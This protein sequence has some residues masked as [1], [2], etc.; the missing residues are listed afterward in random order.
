M[1]DIIPFPPL[2]T[3][4]GRQFSLY[5]RCWYG[6]LTAFLTGLAIGEPVIK[7]LIRHR[8]HQ[9]FRPRQQV[10]NLAILHGPKA[11]V[12][13][14]GGVI[15]LLASFA[16]MALWAAFNDL[17]IVTIII[18]LACTALG[19]L[20]DAMKLIKGNS[21][22]LTSWQKLLVHGLITYLLWRI[23]AKN[24]LL[25]NLITQVNWRWFVAKFSPGNALVVIF[26]FYFFVIAGTSNAVN[27]TDGVDG[28]AITN[29]IQCLVFFCVIAFYSRNVNVAGKSLLT[30][31]AGAGELAVLCA[32]FAGGSLAFFRFNLSPAFVFMGDMGA[33]GLGGLLAIIA[34]LLRQ[35]FVLL[36]IGSTF[37]IEAISVTLQV[38]SKRLFRRKIFL[39]APLH[40]HFELK[41]YSE[42]TIVGVVFIWQA[43]CLGI[44]FYITFYEYFKSP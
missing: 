39:M 5:Q 6:F 10:H 2:V 17:V 26:I 12:P 13:T 15:V 41:G 35:P 11:G 29:V 22:G 3:L 44:A 42:H 25:D 21:K 27:L 20:D 8:I 7:F 4:F 9:I 36:L 38:A 16:A 28:L 37:V 43:I 18:Y 24:P 14:M 1:L 40:H 30:Y 34:I 33:I 23:V 31:I 32:C 19:A